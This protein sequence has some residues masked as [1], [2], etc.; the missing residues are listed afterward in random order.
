MYLLDVSMIVYGQLIF[1]LK[2]ALQI[3]NVLMFLFL[4]PALF[5]IIIIN[6]KQLKHFYF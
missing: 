5:F 4:A 3:G 6:N 2:K 1:I